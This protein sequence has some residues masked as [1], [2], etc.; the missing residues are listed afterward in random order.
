MSPTPEQIAKLPVWAQGHIKDLTRQRDTAK[1][2]HS[3]FL[4]SQTKSAFYEEF[5]GDKMEKRRYVQADNMVC[6]WRGVRLRISAHDYG[7]SGVG[8]LLQWEDSERHGRDVA[9]IPGSFQYA[10]LVSK[11][12]MS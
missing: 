1:K 6:E 10:R 5:L 11:D 3:E 12:D 9:F 7:N 2:E 4:D 8:I